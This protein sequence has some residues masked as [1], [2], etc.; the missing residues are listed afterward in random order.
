MRNPLAVTVLLVTGLLLLGFASVSEA[1]LV[2][3]DDFN[4]KPINPAKWSGF[5]SDFGPAAPNTET[6]RKIANGKLNLVLTS[7][8]RTDSDTGT[9]GNA[10]VSLEINNPTVVTTIQVDVTVKSAKVRGCAFNTTA[11]RAAARVMGDFFSDGTSPGPGDRT[12]DIIAGTVSQRDSLAGDQIVAFVARCT[13][14]SCGSSTTLASQVFAATWTKGV[15][16]TIRMQW[17]PSP[18]KQFVFTLNPA[19][20]S[21]E[22]HTLS[23]AVSD[24]TPPVL[25]HRRLYTLT[26]PANCMSG[27]RTSATAKVV[28]DN[29]MVNP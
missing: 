29:V 9:L 27:P 3:Y 17:L 18:T 13:N 5:E 25:P 4:S 2:L 16:D 20:P 19:G 26:R 24:T 15:A 10:L 28:F 23:Y 11:T 6:A 1:Q 22:T 7:Y 8:G 14:A 21:P 12:G